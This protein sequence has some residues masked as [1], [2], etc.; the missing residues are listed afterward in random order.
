MQRLTSALFLGIVAGEAIAQG[1]LRADLMGPHADFGCSSCHTPHSASI[2]G[3]QYGSSRVPLWGE[4]DT[5][6]YGGGARSYLTA[7]T[8]ERS[9]ILVCLSCHD[10][11]LAYRA[12]MK[13]KIYETLPE[14]DENCAPR[15]FTERSQTLGP[16]FA[17]HPVGLDTQMGCG[18]AKEWDCTIKDGVIVMDGEKSARF[19]SAYGLFNKPHSYEGKEVVVCTTCHDP[20]SQN[21]IRVDKK[22]SSRAFQP[23]IYATSSFLRAPYMPQ[24]WSTSSNLSAQFCRQCHAD[25]SNE[26]NGSLS[27]TVM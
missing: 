11:N 7:K 14:C 17:E 6:V 1:G 12:T 24:S 3:D 10:G 21:A 20:H 19:V 15:T 26:M 27:G 5:K 16:D 9:G 18:G 8:P 23:G 25:M 13:D 4:T 2:R 22:T